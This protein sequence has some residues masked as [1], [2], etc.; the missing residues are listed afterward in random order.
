MIHSRRKNIKI[1]FLQK[2]TDPPLVLIA[3]LMSAEFNRGDIHRHNL[4][5]PGRSGFL[6]RCGGVPRKT[7][8]TCHRTCLRVFSSIKC[9]NPNQRKFSGAHLVPIHVSSFLS[10]LV[11]VGDVI[12]MVRN[13]TQL[14]HC[15]HWRGFPYMG[16][17][18]IGVQVVMIIYSNHNKIL[19]SAI[20]PDQRL[21]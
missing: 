9:T 6:R 20:T 17:S 2:D 18:R 7:F 14:L 4:L 3:N 15:T 12:V 13:D 8:L 16:K 21:L 5:L 19:R 11:N 1:S 10:E